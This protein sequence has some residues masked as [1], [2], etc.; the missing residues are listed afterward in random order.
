MKKSTCPHCGGNIRMVTVS[1]P[2]AIY[3]CLKCEEDLLFDTRTDKFYTGMKN[4]GAPE[5]K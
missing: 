2:F 1:E 4:N 3:H 5:W